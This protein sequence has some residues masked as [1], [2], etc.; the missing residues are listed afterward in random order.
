MPEQSLFERLGGLLKLRQVHRIFY[1]KVFAHPWLG[2]Y[3]ANN[4]QEALESQQTDFMAQ[5]MGGPARYSGRRPASAHEHL[6]VSD[7]LFDLRSALLGE[8]IAQAGVPA[9]LAHEW[10]TLDDA[11]RR[12]ITKAGIEEC[13]KRWTTDSIIA[14]ERPDAR[15]RA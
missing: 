6:L 13:K 11:F 5:I 4:R 15:R 10:L 7:E 2:L 9:E 8:S 14:H 3:F 12:R 1:D